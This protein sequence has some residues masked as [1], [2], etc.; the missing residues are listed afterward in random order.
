MQCTMQQQ[1]AVLEQVTAKVGE[2]IANLIEKQV[3]SEEV[4]TLEEKEAATLR[5]ITEVGYELLSGLLRLHATPYVADTV[6]CHCGGQADYQGQ[7]YGGVQDH[8]C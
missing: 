5:V 2:V 4:W 3:E 1:Q 6:P 7:R 8:C